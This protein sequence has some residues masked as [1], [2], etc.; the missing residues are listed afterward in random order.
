MEPIITVRQP[1]ASAIF[2][3]GKDVENRT[4]SVE[5]R[6]RIWIHAAKTID[7]TADPRLSFLIRDLPIGVVLGHVDLV[8]VVEDSDS[9]WAR[10]DSFHWLLA[11]A[12]PLGIHVPRR[13]WPG[14]TYWNP[15][16]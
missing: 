4:W 9:R 8:D 16:R 7:R 15:P 2:R 1:W 6:G 13:G 10:P 5:H 3:A 12:H 14:L 11:N